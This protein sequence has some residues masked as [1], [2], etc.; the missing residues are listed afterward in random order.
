MFAVS[1]TQDEEMT[2]FEE[3]YD[4]GHGETLEL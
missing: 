3:E 1:E 4:H 2:F